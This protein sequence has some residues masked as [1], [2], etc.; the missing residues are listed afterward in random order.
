[1]DESKSMFRFLKSTPARV[2]TAVLLVQMAGLLAV[3][4][5]EN[6]PLTLPLSEFPAQLGD[7]SLAQEGQ[8]DQD[9]MAVLKADDVLSRVY[10]DATRR[11]AASLFVAYFKSQRTGQ[12]VHSPKNCLPGS[13]WTPSE[14]SVVPIT[15]PG[16]A[17]PILVNRYVVAKGD[18][19]SLVL[20]WYQSRDRVIASEYRAKFYL[21]ADAIRY[22][23]TDTALVRIIVPVSGNDTATA[24]ATAEDFV[25]ASFVAL[26]R[27]MPA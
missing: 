10:A 9:T 21:V 11:S 8:V 20:Y 27:H 12:T 18:E 3:S 6:V 1:M 14:S 5:R 23:H 13:G 7:W 25:Q 24:T 2:L 16:R 17:E 15:I 22:N 4:R 26:R 19:K